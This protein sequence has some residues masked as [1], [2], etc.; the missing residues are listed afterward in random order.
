MYQL[1]HSSL[2]TRR[3]EDIPTK[4]R[5]FVQ[6]QNQDL[7]IEHILKT[8]R[9]SQPYSLLKSLILTSNGPGMSSLQTSC[10]GTPNFTFSNRRGYGNVFGCPQD[11]TTLLNVAARLCILLAQLLIFPGWLMLG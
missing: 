10:K 9:H 8:A 11:V 4:G 3:P 6:L 1:F 7:H 5:F 2:M